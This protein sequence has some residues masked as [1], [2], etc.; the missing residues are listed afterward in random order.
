VSLA[1][2]LVVHDDRR[3]GLAQTFWYEQE[4]RDRVPVSRS[5]ADASPLE[6]GFYVNVDDGELDGPRLRREP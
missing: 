5:V 2:V 4:C 3:R 6:S 1:V